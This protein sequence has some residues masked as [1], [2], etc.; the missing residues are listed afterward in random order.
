MVPHKIAA[1]AILKYNKEGLEGLTCP[2]EGGGSITEISK[3]VLPKYV[4]RK[5]PAQPWQS[6]R[7]ACPWRKSAPRCWKFS[8]KRYDSGTVLR[9]D[10]VAM[11]AVP[12]GTFLRAWVLLVWLACPQKEAFTLKELEKLGTK[13]GVGPSMTGWVPVHLLLCVEWS[14]VLACFHHLPVTQTIKDVVQSLVDDGLVELEKIGSANYF[15]SFPSKTLC[16]VVFVV[17]P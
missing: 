6:A 13:A 8:M 3:K 5:K 2:G 17:F 14:L 4:P 10:V 9:N 11:A 12:C 16:L 1:P 15:W 7:K